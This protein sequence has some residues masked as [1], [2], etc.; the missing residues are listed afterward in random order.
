MV[1]AREAM[2]CESLRA[3]KALPSKVHRMEENPYGSSGSREVGLGKERVEGET[4][5]HEL[6]LLNNQTFNVVEFADCYFSFL[7]NFFGD[8]QSLLD[9]S[10][11][12]LSALMKVYKVSLN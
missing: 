4:F 3:A 12:Q 10:P 7:E 8:Y 5:R 11:V 9:K 2:Q 1:D 6:S